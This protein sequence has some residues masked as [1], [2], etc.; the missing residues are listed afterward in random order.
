[1][2]ETSS[3]L[4]FWVPALILGLALIAASYVGGD[5]FYRAKTSADNVITVTGAAERTIASDTVKWSAAFSRS[6][7][8]AGLRD[9][10]SGMKQDLEAVK[11]ALKDRGISDAAVAVQPMHVNTTCES[12]SNIQYDPS[13][14]F[15]GS[16]K[17]AGYNL[18]QTLVV[19]LNDVGLI[20]KASQE[21]P[22]LLVDKGIVFSTVSIEYYYSKLADLK[23]EML[24]EA[25]KNAK[26]RAM[27]IAE[28]TGAKI[29]KIQSANVGVF[30]V[31]AV[32]STDISDYGTYD[33]SSIQKK[34]TS[35]VRTVFQL[36]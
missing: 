12:Q 32:N 22:S 1:M 25:T 17:V 26:D 4:S 35:V 8:A 19:E 29:G 11:R 13:G 36:Q 15:C 23:L 27:K 33:T 2:S 24:S 31:T 34:V 16:G 21:V 20:S 5:A 30:Q 9:G 6:V 10:S 14:S 28:S 3:R 18:S 7:D